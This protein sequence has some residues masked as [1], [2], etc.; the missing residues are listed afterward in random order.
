MFDLLKSI[1]ARAEEPMPTAPDEKPFVPGI[2]DLVMLDIETLG[3]SP[4]CVVLSV[5]AAT[6]RWDGTVVAQFSANMDVDQQLAL[7]LEKDQD[8]MDWWGEQSVEA[9]NRAFSHQQPAKQV[10]ID[11]TAWL[12]ANTNGVFKLYAQGQDFDAPILAAVYRKV[13]GSEPPWAFWQ[14]R[15]TR[16]A[17]D[18]SG[19]NVHVVERYGTH[20]AAIDDVLHQI[21][22]LT[23]ARRMAYNPLSKPEA[24]NDGG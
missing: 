14:L 20:H 16:T 8:T 13:L 4:G 6:F 18:V 24:A 22:C 1:F 19:L 12:E 23:I 5:A 11:L 9:R 3:T 2:E 7:G 21:R 17:Y 15:D 10:L